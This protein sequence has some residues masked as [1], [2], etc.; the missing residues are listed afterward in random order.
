M[1]LLVASAA[2][3][4]GSNYVRMFARGEFQGASSIKVLDELTYA[5]FKA[6]LKVAAGLFQYEFVK[7]DICRP[8][9]VSE[10]LKEADAVVNFAAE[11][12]VDR[13]IPGA[14]DFVRTNIVGVQVILDEKVEIKWGMDLGELKISE[15]DKNASTLD[16]RFTEGKL[17]GLK[18]LGLA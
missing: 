18:S 1:K 10:L 17:P 11:S 14:A 6:N 5:A 13:S 7:S 3:F 4:I 12:H 8:G 2:G 9:V 16:E 15:K